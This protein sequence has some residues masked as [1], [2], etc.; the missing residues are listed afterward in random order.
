MT[1][2]VAGQ[3]IDVKIIRHEADRLLAR[4]VYHR[5]L[6]EAHHTAEGMVEPMRSVTGRSAYD[7]AISAAQAMV[8]SLEDL[9]RRTNATPVSPATLVKAALGP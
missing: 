3:S 1:T 9:S 5:A 6:S 4:L 2:R 8:V 7:E